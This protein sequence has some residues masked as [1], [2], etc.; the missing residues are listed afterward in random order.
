M[1]FMLSVANKPIM[2]TVVVP[3]YD[4]KTF[5]QNPVK[6]EMGITQKSISLMLARL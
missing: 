4:G 1:S 2:L 6:N 3:K 5:F